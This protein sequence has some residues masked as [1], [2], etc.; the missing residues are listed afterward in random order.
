MGFDIDGALERYE[1]ET[2]R[3]AEIGREPTLIEK[4]ILGHGQIVPLDKIPMNQVF[5]DGDTPLKEPY[6]FIMHNGVKKQALI[7][8]YPW[9]VFIPVKGRNN[10]YVLLT[11]NKYCKDVLGVDLHPKYLRV[12][13]SMNLYETIYL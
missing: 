1:K 11:D 3:K 10:R 4:G 5:V 8:R 9:I 12:Q 13:I 6:I 7:K 2:G